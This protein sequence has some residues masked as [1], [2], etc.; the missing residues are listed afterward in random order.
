MSG[1]LLGHLQIGNFGVGLLD[2]DRE[3]AV[4]AASTQRFISRRHRR[5]QA[6]RR[7]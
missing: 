5:E 3:A 4:S 6:W 1:P 7:A 2:L